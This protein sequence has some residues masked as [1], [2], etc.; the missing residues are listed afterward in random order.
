MLVE[1]KDVERSTK[2]STVVTLFKP[3]TIET[4]ITVL[5]PPFVEKSEKIRMN[6]GTGEYMERA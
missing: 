6:T 3:A 1:I 4:G 5:V 2:G